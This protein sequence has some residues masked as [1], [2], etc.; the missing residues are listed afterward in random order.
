MIP[1]EMGVNLADATLHLRY[2]GR[3]T[4]VDLAA[5]R[6]RAIPSVGDE[7]APLVAGSGRPAFDPN[8][9]P[10]AFVNGKVPVDLPTGEGRGVPGFQPQSV[11]T[12]D[13]EGGAVRVERFWVA[14]NTLRLSEIA[15]STSAGFG[16]AR[17]GLVTPLGEILVDEA[18]EPVTQA[19]HTVSI[20]LG[21]PPGEYWAVIWSEVPLTL[22]AIAGV[23]PEQGWDL[24]VGGAPVFTS[25]E[26]ADLDLAEG[27]FLDGAPLDSVTQ[28][29][30]GEVKAILL[31]WSL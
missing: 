3:K 30:P 29:T 27:L 18:L 7:G 21:L 14:S 31:K 11:T 12:V 8:L 25:A 22:D 20:D 9:A 15:V 1:G 10:A 19:V 4:T 13:L 5:V 26:T 24:N 23:R 6:D 28:P 2:D 17:F 16:M